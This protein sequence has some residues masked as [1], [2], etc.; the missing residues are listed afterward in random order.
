MVSV[1]KKRIG[2]PTDEPKTIVKRAR[3][4]QND[5]E[6]LQI[7]CDVLKKSESEVIR[8]GIDAVYQQLQQKK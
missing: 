5:V 8:L 1:E 2:R 6:K 7:C 4:S 3:V